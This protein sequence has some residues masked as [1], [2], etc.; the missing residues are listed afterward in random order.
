MIYTIQN[1][2]Y[3]KILGIDMDDTII[4]VKSG[5]KFGKNADDWI[6]LNEKVC[7]TLKKYHEDNYSIVI[8]TN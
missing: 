3:P 4:K 6:F 8:F 7:S 5:Q 2:I 1:T